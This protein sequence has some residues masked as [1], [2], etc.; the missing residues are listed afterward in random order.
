[1]RRKRNFGYSGES[2][3][4]TLGLNGKLNEVHA[5]SALASLDKLPV[6]ISR[7]HARLD[8][9]QQAFRGI[10]GI[11]WIPYP[12]DEATNAEFPLLKLATD[13]PIPRDALVSILRA[14]GALARAYYAPALHLQDDSRH[15]SL[16]VAEAL[17]QCIVQMPTGEMVNTTD[18]ARLASL[19]QF[20]SSNAAAIRAALAAHQD[21]K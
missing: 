10:P 5:A 2:S 17:A 13:W 9:Y 6:V 8:A 15:R 1:M 14:E 11:S 18:I 21:A 12:G 16:P 3:I 4:D 19:V 20:V 7:N